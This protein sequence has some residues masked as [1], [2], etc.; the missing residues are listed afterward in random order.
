LKVD[1]A[2]NSFSAGEIGSPLFGRVDVAQYNY[3]CETVENFLV[4]PY[5]SLITTPGTEYI[6]EVK[7][8]SKRTRLLNF[9]FSR[10][11]SYIIEFGDSYFRFYTDGGSVLV[12]TSST[13]YELAH[14][15]KEDELFDVQIA[16][17]N[18]TIYFAHPDHRVKKLIR[19][20]ADDWSFEDFDFL[21]GPFLDDNTS[22]ITINPSAT[23]GTGVTLT[24]S[25]T[26]STVSFVS[27]GATTKGHVDSY[28]KIAGTS[29]SVQGY[30]KIS[31]VISP[32]NATCEVM[33]TL[34]SA[35]ATTDWAEGAWSDVRGYPGS[36]TFHEGRLY[37]A[38]TDY[39]P[40]K[41]WGS[42]IFTYD[43]F[44]AGSED[45]DGLNLQLASNESNEI[46]WLVS[47]KSLVCGTFGGEFTINGGGE[48]ITPS[49][50]L[51]ERATAWGSEK[52][53]PK[54]IGNYFYYVQRFGKKL[55]ELFYFWE[56]ETYKSIDKTILSPHILGEGVIDMDYQQS[57]ENILWC[58]RTDGTL[59]TMTREV[60]QEVQG[61]SRQVTAGTYE[62]IAVIPS[63]EDAYDEVWIIVQ[64]TIDGSTVRYVERFENMEVPDR[65]DKMNYL[66]SSLEYDAY[67]HTIDLSLSGTAG[68][69]TVT[70]SSAAFT[71]ADENR[72]IR[73]IDADG[74]TVGEAK[75]DTVS[76]STVALCTVKLSFDD[77]SYEGGE[78]GVSVEG[79]S[80]LDHLEGETVKVLADGGLDSPDKVVSS[81]TIDLAYNYF[82]IRAGLPYTQT[83]KTLPK[84]GTSP[85]GTAQGKKQRVYEVAFKLNNSYRGFSV[86]DT[87]TQVSW[88]DPA[89]LLGTPEA[90]YTG[91]LSN[92]PLSSNYEYGSQV[93]ITNEDP[94]PIELLSI[95]LMMTSYDK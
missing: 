32:T 74:V 37:F 56:V 3:A 71:S 4:R 83:I 20:G 31:T 17:F 84:E 75:I 25:A 47:G 88:R 76:S 44:T 63:Q 19:S 46:N 7:T 18:D 34:S 66:H 61:W 54:R 64:R 6:A 24:L 95:S 93:E 27:S 36:V 50:V 60:D 86:G 33:Q 38:R 43:D 70:S 30:V 72:R 21:A 85:K 57:P 15:Y 78:W 10:T 67:D 5:G 8:S 16:Q 65:Q 94:L 80:G 92:I 81:G 13:V 35:D 90:L 53:V 52:I 42:Q 77:T 62:S 69:I 73:A 12:G 87:P 48:P 41:V 26:S 45:D 39:E 58:V 22:T 59:A 91:I 29:S 11:D 1:I 68:S 49:N 28:W 2:Q 40:Q 14:I 23:S 89:T 9:I 79:L 55:R 82:V 51:V